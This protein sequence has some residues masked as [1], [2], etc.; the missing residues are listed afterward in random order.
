MV[1]YNRLI[2]GSMPSEIERTQQL[3][4]SK[5]SLGIIVTKAA[6]IDGSFTVRVRGDKECTQFYSGCEKLARD[7]HYNG[8]ELKKKRQKNL[9]YTR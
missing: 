3:V 9:I 1:P 2:N 8:K 6:V 4:I 5:A 7:D